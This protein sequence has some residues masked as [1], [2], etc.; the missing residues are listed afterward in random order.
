M[1]SIIVKRASAR[2]W[3][4]KLN[5]PFRIA[6]GSHKVLEN[7]LFTIELS[8]GIHGCGEAGVATHITGET[9]R[10][11][12]LNLIDATKDMTGMEIDRFPDAADEFS[13]KF[14]RNK[15]ALAAL[16]MAMLDAVTRTK[17]MPLWQAFGNKA[18][19][20][21]TDMT[22]VLG[23]VS[24][25]RADAR[26]IARRRIRSFKVKVGRDFGE[27][28]SR[29]KA[30]AG[31]AR[32]LPIFLDANQGFTVSQTLKFLKR[33]E[34]L[35]IAP[36]LIEQPVAKGDLE[37][38]AKIT[39]ESKTLVFADES[40]GSLEDVKRIVRKKAAGGINIKLM[41]TGLLESYEIAKFARKNN[42]GLMIGCMM[43]TPLA[44]AA[45]A[46]LAAGCGGFDFIDL[47]SPFFMAERVTRGFYPSASGIYDVSK[48][49]AGIGVQPLPG[50]TGSGR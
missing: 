34:E 13:F 7:I 39:R 32:K 6:L 43:E 45:A 5:S 36:A 21:K 47:D 44:V 17:G 14:G 4:A 42:L 35:G 49:R 25:A 3:R 50:P 1:K 16:E 9:V 15:C 27:D 48:V 41:K 22:V 33:L 26:I 24:S 11:T 31:I 18:G 23:S 8:N 38:L 30:V 10:G 37:G 12:L 19:I 28:I 46:H 20:L 40:A 2:I 29:V